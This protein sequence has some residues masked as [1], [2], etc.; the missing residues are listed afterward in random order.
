MLAD[1][2]VINMT[3]AWTNPVLFRSIDYRWNDNSRGRPLCRGLFPR[4]PTSISRHSVTS[5]SFLVVLF[6]SR[7][8]AVDHDCVGTW[9][10]SPRGTTDC[11][12]STVKDGQHT[13]TLKL[14]CLWLSLSDGSMVLNDCVFC[15]RV[16]HVWGK[17]IPCG[18]LNQPLSRS[19]QSWKT[20]FFFAHV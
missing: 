10:L 12:W 18:Y 7:R 9:L 11:S 20:W 14:P 1:V 2:L 3:Y 13:G 4:A 16:R 19:I 17:I 8:P 15:G 6:V 5:A